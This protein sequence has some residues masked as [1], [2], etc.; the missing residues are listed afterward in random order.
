[1][2]LTVF[3]LSWPVQAE[4]NFIE[5]VKDATFQEVQEA[6]EAGADINARNQAGETPLIAAARYNH[7]PQIS[8]SWL[9]MELLLRPEI[10]QVGRFI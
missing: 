10:I 8:F 2:I 1:M 9:K 6:I 7:N 3:I 5:L 4:I